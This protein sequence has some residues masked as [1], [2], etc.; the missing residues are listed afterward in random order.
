MIAEI[1][2]RRPEYV[3]ARAARCTWPISKGILGANGIVGGASARR[4]RA[5]AA[6]LDLAGVW[7][8]CSSAM[9]ALTRVW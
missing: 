2:G 8:P 4:G 1:F 5:P 6:Q 9:A 3:T 7:R